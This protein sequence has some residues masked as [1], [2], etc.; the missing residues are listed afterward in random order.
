M[1]GAIA[2]AGA[3]LA[4]G[5]I[6]NHAA[7]SEASRN[8]SFQERMSNTAHQREIED[9]RKAGLNPILSV[10]KGLSTPSGAMANFTNSAKDAANTFNQAKL[11]KEQLKNIQADTDLKG[12]QATQAMFA[13]LNQAALAKLAQSNAKNADLNNALLQNEVQLQDYIGTK[14]SNI[15][16]AFDIL[17]S[18]TNSKQTK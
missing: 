11:I 2:T 5:L 13:G 1:W 3:S 9:L 10:N 4:G 6:A 17:K 15:K 8:R 18:L 12:E 16:T 14:G 7:R